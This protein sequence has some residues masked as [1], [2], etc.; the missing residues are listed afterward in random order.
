MI[1]RT[2]KDGVKHKLDPSDID[3]L[4]EIDEDD[5][6]SLVWCETHQRYEWHWLPR[7]R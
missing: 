6:L 5:Q 1:E 3:E 7:S 4:D 2:T